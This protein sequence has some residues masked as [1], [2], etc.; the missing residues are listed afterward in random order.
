MEAMHINRERT[1]EKQALQEQLQGLL[2]ERRPTV[3]A[4]AQRA[5]CH[6]GLLP[7]IPL[8]MSKRGGCRW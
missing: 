2:G 3:E 6:A 7:C 8:A 4:F 5:H 1:A